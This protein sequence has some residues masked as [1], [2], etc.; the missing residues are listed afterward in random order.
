LAFVQED[1]LEAFC[2][3]ILNSNEFVFIP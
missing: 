3:A 2:R 1:G